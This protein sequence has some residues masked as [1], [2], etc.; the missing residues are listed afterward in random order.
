LYQAGNAA[1]DGLATETSHMLKRLLGMLGAVHV[2]S[3]ENQ[4]FVNEVRVRMKDREQELL[5]QLVLE[6]GRHEVGGLSFYG[7]LEPEDVKTVGQAL[8]APVAEAA[9]AKAAL[10]ARLSGLPGVEL[11]G[12]P[13]QGRRGLRRDAG[14]VLRGTPSGAAVAGSA[15]P[16]LSSGGRLVVAGLAQ[17]GGSPVPQHARVRQ[18]LLR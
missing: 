12:I 4:I 8:A 1:M 9:Q 3:V 14:E 10:A 17:P 5:D 11:G 16:P 13:P 7:P 18:H 15:P 2:V 6:L